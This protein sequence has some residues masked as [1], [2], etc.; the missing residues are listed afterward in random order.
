M[1]LFGNNGPKLP[2]T[3]GARRFDL[4]CLIQGCESI[5]D[6]P[7]PH[8]DS[9]NYFVFVNRPSL[10]DYPFVDDHGRR[11]ACPKELLLPTQAVPRTILRSFEGSKCFLPTVTSCAG[12]DEITVIIC[13][14][15]THSDDMIDF[16][17]HVW[18]EL[19]AVTA[20]E[21]VSFEDSPT[22]A[23]PVSSDVSRSHAI[24][25]H[26]CIVCMQCMA[27]RSR[28]EV[29]AAYAETMRRR[30]L[31][32]GKNYA[33]GYAADPTLRSRE[34]RCIPRA[35]LAPRRSLHSRAESVRP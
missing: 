26:Y 34:G 35:Y 3:V 16:E 29:C 12:C 2:R 13:A 21:I 9:S 6:C 25:M 1:K 31:G 17:H 15:F 23:I 19:S 10:L 20:R 18:R 11:W 8:R 4:A 28:S 32:G 5:S 27:H 14:H 24:S 22:T 33:R 7:C 30:P